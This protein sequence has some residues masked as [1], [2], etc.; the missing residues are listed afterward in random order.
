MKK[1]K[2]LLLLALVLCL[3]L[4][5]TPKPANAA[6]WVDYDIVR[7]DYS[8]YQNGN[9]KLSQ[10]YDQVVVRGN[11]LQA[12]NIN[13]V[14]QGHCDQFIAEAPNRINMTQAHPPRDGDQ[15]FYYYNTAVTRNS[16]GIFSVK[17]RLDWYMGGLSNDAYEGFNFDLNTGEELQLNN[18]FYMSDY[19]IEN[20]LKGQTYNYINTHPNMLW[21]D[22]GRVYDKVSSYALDDFD[23]YIDGNNVVLLYDKYEL[24]P[25]ALGA[26]AISVPIINNTIN[27]YLD[28]QKLSFDQPP[29]MAQNRT[30]VPIRAIFEALGY[31]VSWNQ[32]SQMGI[33]VN[34]QNTIIVQVGNA[35]VNYNGGTYW[36][37]VAP[38]N[39]NGRI[40]VPLRAIAE[41]A[42]CSVYWYQS[43]QTVTIT[44]N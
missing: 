34:G 33:A 26:V 22:D 10:Y 32:K 7:N 19:D 36:C 17:T 15:Y 6:D 40:L 8:W 43:T 12:M 37:D 13:A 11:S 35:Q 16:G 42:G 30:M 21:W 9:L 2:N 41:S 5:A 39:K 38:M 44:S 18:L 28:G 29:I 4:C 14:L 1:R 27:V 3:A 20:Y 31:E 25:G 23:F 24:G